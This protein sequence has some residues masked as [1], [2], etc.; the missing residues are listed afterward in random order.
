[1]NDDIKLINIGEVEIWRTLDFLGYPDY[2]V[3]TRGNV[4]HLP[5]E[6]NRKD[7]YII[8]QTNT[9]GYKHIALYKDGKVTLYLLHRL[10]ALAFIPQ[11]NDKCNEINHLDENKENNRVENLQWTTH[12]KNSRYGTRGQ[13]ISE[14]NKGKPK[15][16]RKNKIL[17]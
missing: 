16:R 17:D 7:K 12:L 1:M 5:N 11:P 14:S 6:K 9:C 10:V 13:R 8:P 3:S 2:I 15:I 4:R